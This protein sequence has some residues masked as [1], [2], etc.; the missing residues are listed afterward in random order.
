MPIFRVSYPTLG[1][2]ATIA[3]IMT[4]SKFEFLS[5]PSAVRIFAVQDAGD[6]ATLDFTLGNVVIG[7]DLPLS[8]V[9]AGTGPSMT[10]DKLVAGVGSP[11]DRIQIRLRETGGAAAAITRIAVEIAELA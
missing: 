2:G 4:G 10:D 9:T 8:Q 11:G 1:A 7:E 3:N 6:L 5:R